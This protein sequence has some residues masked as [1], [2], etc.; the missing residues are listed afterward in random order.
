MDNIHLS[1]R[2]EDLLR[3]SRGKALRHA[4]RGLACDVTTKA[5]TIE[6]RHY[7]LD[8]KLQ[9]TSARESSRTTCFARRNTSSTSIAGSAELHDPVFAEVARC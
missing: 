1:I 5:L 3:S 7:F 2:V 6:Y 9:N 4:L 8:A